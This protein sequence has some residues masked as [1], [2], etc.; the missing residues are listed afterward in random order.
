MSTH[1]YLYIPLAGKH[2]A[3][4]IRTQL[5]DYTSAEYQHCED[6]P[7]PNMLVYYLDLGEGITPSKREVI[8]R[9]LLPYVRHYGLGIYLKR[10]D[11]LPIRRIVADLD[12]CMVREELL[13]RLS[14]GKAFASEVETATQAAMSGKESFEE[15][16]SKRIQHLKG[17]PVSTL[18]T[19]AYEVPLA[20]GSEYLQHFIEGEE[21]QLD[22]AS[23][24]LVPY[25]HHLSLRLNAHS[26]VATMPSMDESEVLD[27]S[28]VAPIIGAQEKRQFLLEHCNERQ[29]ET[30]VLAIGD[31]ANDLKMLTTAGHALLYSACAADSLNIAHIVMDLYF[32]GLSRHET[33]PQ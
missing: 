20:Q 9:D 12:G 8:L 3:E 10:A 32:R 33:P 18:E 29:P 16:F 25:V 28:L 11:A 13:V 19:I 1:L 27:G 4:A 24:N 21:L 6:C 26:Y 15:N 2:L 17:L 5:Q 22:I 7:S 14:Q 31:G 23:S 30:A